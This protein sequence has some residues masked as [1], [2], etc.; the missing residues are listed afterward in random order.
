MENTFCEKEDTHTA[1]GEISEYQVRLAFPWSW[2][3]CLEH[4]TYPD[5]GSAQA[6]GLRGLSLGIPA[7]AP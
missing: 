3:L 4:L 7:D 1:L 2:E 6:E 5:S